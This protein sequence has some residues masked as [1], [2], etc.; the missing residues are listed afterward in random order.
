VFKGFFKPEELV[1][2]LYAEQDDICSVL[3]LENGNLLSVSEDGAV[4]MWNIKNGDLMATIKLEKE[5]L[6][7]LLKDDRMAFF[8]Y[9]DGSVR[10]RSLNASG[11]LTTTKTLRNT[12]KE[13]WED[14]VFYHVKITQ[15]SNGNLAVAYYA[16]YLFN[17]GY[18]Y[19]NIW[20]LDSSEGQLLRKIACPDFKRFI[21]LPHGNIAA[22]EYI[23][24]FDAGLKI[25]SSI[26]I[27]NTSTGELVKKL[28]SEKRQR[29]H[30]FILLNQT[31]VASCCGMEIS[32]WDLSTGLKQKTLTGA[33]EINSYEEIYS[34][35]LCWDGS[36]VS[37]YPKVSFVRP[38]LFPRLGFWNWQTGNLIRTL[39]ISILNSE[40]LFLK[41]VKYLIAIDFDRLYLWN[42]KF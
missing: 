11:S 26:H 21:A 36:L 6:L 40:I 32:I 35:S 30:D 15:L 31:T 38:M 2:V 18:G 3:E 23:N 13:E 29:V 25:G 7:D 12:M 24:P 1:T 39:D 37:C 10:I 14:K 22:W 42:V 8:D 27:W 28:S 41:K 4:K 20:S 34:L 16:H 19:M 33:A 9:R 17:Y 5:K